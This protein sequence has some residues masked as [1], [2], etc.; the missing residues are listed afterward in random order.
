MVDACKCKGGKF[1][2][3]MKVTCL[4][5]PASLEQIFAK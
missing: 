3:M 1:L 2:F 5:H 4:A